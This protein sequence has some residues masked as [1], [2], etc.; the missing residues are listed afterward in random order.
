MYA[1]DF[2]ESFKVSLYVARNFGQSDD[3]PKFM[4]GT[5][6]PSHVYSNL[7][8]VAQLTV[9]DTVLEE[10]QD[11]KL[12]KLGG[13]TTTKARGMWGGKYEQTTIIT[14]WI[15]PKDLQALLTRLG[16]LA[17]A[18]KLGTYQDTVAVTIERMYVN[19]V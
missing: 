10:L 8:R 4:R 11:G 6:I 15:A 5:P 14:A 17:R 19:F 3:L 12:T 7:I 2:N 1:S 16:G 13:S 18:I 9:A